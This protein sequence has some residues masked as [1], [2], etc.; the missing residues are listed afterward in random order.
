MTGAVLE[1]TPDPDEPT[2]IRGLRLLDEVEMR[3]LFQS[4]NALLNAGFA[5]GEADLLGSA[6]RYDQAVA[7]S[8]LASNPGLNGNV[9]VVKGVLDRENGRVA[10]DVDAG[11]G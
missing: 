9:G 2:A 4:Y 1:V 7:I 10:V 8:S 11:A 6:P 5:P 3:H